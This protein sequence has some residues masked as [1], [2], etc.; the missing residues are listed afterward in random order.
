MSTSPASVERMTSS[1]SP[2]GGGFGSILTIILVVACI[3]LLITCLLLYS[4][5][6]ELQKT[7]DTQKTELET[8]KKDLDA[9]R[10]QL[11]NKT[12]E[13][14][15]LRADLGKAIRIASLPAPLQGATPGE[16]MDKIQQLLAGGRPLTPAPTTGQTPGSGPGV[17]PASVAADSPAALLETIARQV[18]TKSFNTKE[19][20]GSDAAKQQMHRGAQIVLAR[21][22][23]FAKPI[24]GNP[25][26]TYDAVV[27]F[28]KANGLKADGIIGKNTWGKVREKFD[29]LPR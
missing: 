11:A 19:A 28:Q 27:A 21:I 6:N 5:K 10:G 17:T 2:S 26:D 25:Q 24:S 4:G 22:G 20:I 9:S 8:A 14:D 15:A 13:A 1:K 12:R 3:G 7:F 23:A 29:A 16:S 18:A